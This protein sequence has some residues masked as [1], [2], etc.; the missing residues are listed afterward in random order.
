[1]YTLGPQ[2][3]QVIN[4]QQMG[5]LPQTIALGVA[6]AAVLALARR[7]SLVRQRRVTW[8]C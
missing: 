5:W 4:L 1:M 8:P 7:S 2:G 3:A 6:I